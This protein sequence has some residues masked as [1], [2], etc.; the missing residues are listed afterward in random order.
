MCAAHGNWNAMQFRCNEQHK[1]PICFAFYDEHVCSACHSGMSNMRLSFY[2]T[3][4]SILMVS[5]SIIFMILMSRTR[6]PSPA[7]DPLIHHL[8]CNLWPFPS[9]TWFMN[10]N[11]EFP[12]LYLVSHCLK[13]TAK[14]LLLRWM[15]RQP[16][17]EECIKKCMRACRVYL[18]K[19]AWARD[20]NHHHRTLRKIW[21]RIISFSLRIW[22][23][24]LLTATAADTMHCA[25]NAMTKR[26]FV[27]RQTGFDAW[28]VAFESCFFVHQFRLESNSVDTF[29][30][31]TLCWPRKT[32]KNKWQIQMGRCQRACQ[33]S[34]IYLGFSFAQFNWF[35]LSFEQSQLLRAS[36]NDGVSPFYPHVLVQTHVHCV[37]H[38]TDTLCLPPIS[39]G[40]ESLCVCVC[41]LEEPTQSVAVW[42]LCM[43][44]TT[45]INNNNLA[46][47]FIL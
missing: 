33:T 43:R 44:A 16:E 2:F 1:R 13:I 45:S 4:S 10:V 8:L 47:V 27:S 36:C 12:N 26:M 7:L 37:L 31:V 24:D 15:S 41:C 40:D 18:V 23:P 20:R 6:T 11:A 42:S 32:W 38:T 29:W 35:R 5:T 9:P 28:M 21:T 46:N 34:S 25:V 19:P 3:Y 30:R 17:D 14:L 22:P 39:P